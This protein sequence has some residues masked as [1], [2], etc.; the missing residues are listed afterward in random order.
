MVCAARILHAK[1]EE[2]FNEEEFLQSVSVYELDV[3]TDQV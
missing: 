1:S 2:V 3:M